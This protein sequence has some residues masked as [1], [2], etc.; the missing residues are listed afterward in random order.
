MMRMNHLAY[1]LLLSASGCEKTDPLFCQMN[2]NATGCGM[3]MMGD[4]ADV[5]DQDGDIDPD[6]APTADAQMCFGADNY[7]FCL[8][9]LPT[10]PVA[11]ADLSTIN[12]G[13]DTRCQAPPADWTSH[14]Q[15]DACFIIAT[16]INITNVGVSGTKPLVL[17]GTNAVIINGHLDASSH[18]TGNKLG[19]GAPAPSSDCPDYPTDPAD[20]A[21]GSA[22]A[23]GGGAGASFMTV[24]RNGG[25]GDNMVTAGGTSFAALSTGPVVL[26]AGCSGQNGGEGD[27]GSGGTGGG[28]G[29]AVFVVAGNSITLGANGVISASGG[30]ATAA[31]D[32]AGGAGGGS[33]GMIVLYGSSITVTSGARLIANGGGGGTGGNNGG[34]SAG[35]EPGIADPTSP[36]GGT[37]GCG[38]CG[39]GGGGAAAGTPA[40]IGGDGSDNNGGGGG[41]GGLGYIVSN[42]DLTGIAAS[43]T[44]TTIPN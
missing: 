18:R 42:K 11:V 6:M 3:M 25:S 44:P 33:G 5:T 27:G 34:G 35:N 10:T 38:G 2:P 12:T 15:P 20:N 21:N 7:A 13:T 29:G 14:S 26:R 36:A 16:N 32:Q 41:G 8:T 28:G 40:A 19:P 23:G 31:G 9:A 4:D 22:S 17:V 24:G 37:S 1:A 39:T 30:G 43:P